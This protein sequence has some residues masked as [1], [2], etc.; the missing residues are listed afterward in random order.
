ML[1]TN[2]CVVRKISNDDYDDVKE[3]YLNEEV[4]KYLGGTREIGS[5]ST[6]IAQMV[7]PPDHS[8]YWKIKDK[9]TDSF[10]GLI[11]LDPHHSGDQLEISYQLLPQWWGKGYAGEVLSSVL[12]YVF[13]VLKLP[14]VVAETQTANLRS[15]RLL[16]KSGMK[17][18]TIRQRFGAEQSIYQIERDDLK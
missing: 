4:R 1:E 13:T 12:H 7:M 6:I 3:I 9:R 10:V 18:V 11:S 16:E 5:I 17:L 2:R 15:R 14:R 8:F